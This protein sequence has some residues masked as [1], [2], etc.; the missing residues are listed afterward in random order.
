MAY[1]LARVA[2]E[3]SAWWLVIGRNADA[4]REMKEACKTADESNSCESDN[5]EKTSP[6]KLK[7]ART[8]KSRRASVS[9]RG[10][11]EVCSKTEL[12]HLTNQSK[13]ASAKSRSCKKT[14]RQTSNASSKTDP[15]ENTLKTNQNS[16]KLKNEKRKRGHK[17]SV[18]ETSYNG[19]ERNLPAYNEL[20]QFDVVTMVSQVSVSD[21]EAEGG[22]SV[23]IVACHNSNPLPSNLVGP[24]SP[25]QLEE[26]ISKQF[27][28]RKTKKK[29]LSIDS[30]QHVKHKWE[31]TESQ[32]EKLT[33]RT[34]MCVSLNK[35]GSRQLNI[36]ENMTEERRE[37]EFS[38][39]RELIEIKEPKN[40]EHTVEKKC[41]KLFE[42]SNQTDQEK[43][44]S[45]IKTSSLNHVEKQLATPLDE[46]TG[47][48]KN[49]L[50]N[51]GI[52]INSGT[53]TIQKE[54][55]NKCIQGKQ[56][57]N[58]L[59]IYPITIEDY[60]LEM[61][62]R[63]LGNSGS[64]TLGII[65]GGVVCFELNILMTEL[66]LKIETTLKDYRKIT[67]VR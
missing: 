17:Q 38:Q 25:W 67:V 15:R 46:L 61:L 20:P 51:K 11:Q 47:S 24:L 50:E 49:A 8:K 42:I 3:Q 48:A 12:N 66:I 23:N 6:Q 28:I 27:K 1:C 14:N 58:E 35:S 18:K 62:K 53:R 36:F 60:A 19:K 54:T 45:K 32:D 10:E 33:S 56:L 44:F 57:E 41:R 37:D 59:G 34:S 16:V 22:K 43:S 55:C 26:N 13:L 9:K 63:T 7:K 52:W 39:N 4:E 30:E 40:V 2:R 5:S 64:C 21:N 65:T 29:K 31:E